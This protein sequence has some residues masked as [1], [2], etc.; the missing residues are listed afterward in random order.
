MFADNC[1]S[2]K[3]RSTDRCNLD[4]YITIRILLGYLSK[5]CIGHKLITFTAF[6]TFSRMGLR[7]LWVIL[8]D[9]FRQLQGLNRDNFDKGAGCKLNI[10]IILNKRGY[11][12]SANATLLKE[13]KH[14]FLMI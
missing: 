3:V 4:Y 13:Q 8:V 12:L 7:L 9:G 14:L 1:F 2:Q 10:K 6:N 11:G 5:I